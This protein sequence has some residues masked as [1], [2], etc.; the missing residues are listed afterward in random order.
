MSKED[1]LR[2][3]LDSGIVAVVRSPDSQ[4]L[5]NVATALAEGGVTVI[6]ITMTV[7]DA[8][9][10]VRR[11]RQALGDKILLGAV[12]FSTPRPPEPLLLAGCRIL[13]GAD[14]QSRRNQ[15][16]SA[17]RQASDAG[18]VHADGDPCRVGGGSRHCQS[19]SRGNRRA[20][21]L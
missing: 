7:P 15:T 8:L 6:E 1:Q 11:V 12:R 3:V 13:G 2:R 17:R 5:V 14:A 10:V 4:Q 18:R 21:V 19:V 9:D 16:L 20:S